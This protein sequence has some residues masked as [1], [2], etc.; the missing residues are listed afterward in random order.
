VG[1][2]VSMKYRTHPL[3]SMRKTEGPVGLV[4]ELQGQSPTS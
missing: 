3:Y 2:A 1:P 4:A